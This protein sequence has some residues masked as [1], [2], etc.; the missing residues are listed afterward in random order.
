MIPWRFRAP[1]VSAFVG[2]VGFRVLSR[3]PLLAAFV[4][5]IAAV[6]YQIEDEGQRRL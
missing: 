3:F 6:R 4:L 2:V 1:F 5:S